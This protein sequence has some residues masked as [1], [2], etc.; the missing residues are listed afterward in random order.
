MNKEFHLGT[1]VSNLTYAILKNNIIEDIKNNSRVT[2]F[3]VN[4]EKLIKASKN[5]HLKNVL[6]DGTY[7]IPD[8]IGVVLASK[9]KKGIINQRITGIDCMDMLCKLSNEKGYKIFIY[10]SE[11]EVGLQAIENLKEK[12]KNIKIVGYSHGYLKDDKILI[13]KIN[14][15]KPHIVFVA[16]G[17]PLQEM[18][19]HKNKDLINASVFQGVGGSLDVISGKISRAPQWMQKLGLE[20]FYRL[21]KQP[22]RIKR[23]FSLLQ[24]LYCVLFKEE[25]YEN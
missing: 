22:A 5:Q 13:E 4:P 17:S 16:L 10:G 25:R 1:K 14:K 3:A 18:W 11:E 8:G 24:Y 20:W 21:I 15:L 12:F 23:Q 2:I 9:L 19:I 7:N 6:N